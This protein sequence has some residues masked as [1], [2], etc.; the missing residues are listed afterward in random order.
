MPAEHGEHDHEADDI[1]QEA[2]AERP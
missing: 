2:P 1:S